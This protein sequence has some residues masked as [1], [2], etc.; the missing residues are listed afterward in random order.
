MEKETEADR[1]WTIIDRIGICMLTTRG[2]AGLR[3]RPLQARPDRDAGVVWFVTDM[4]SEKEQEVA[5]DH[6]VGLVFVDPD[7]NVYLSIT[8]SAKALRDREIAASIW[9]LTDNMWWDGPDDPNAGLL[10]VTPR[11]AELWDGPS[12]RA[13]VAFEFLKSQIVGSPPHLGENRKTVV[14][15]DR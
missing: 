9:H 13:S 15:M 11:T 5:S 10:R 12:S 3:A 14:D 1:I 2:P 8:V 4:R 7:N 6:D